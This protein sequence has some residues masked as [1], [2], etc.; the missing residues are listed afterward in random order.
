VYAA[1]GYEIV[2]L[3]EG[4][5][6]PLR[7]LKF[8]V[9]DYG[10]LATG[11]ACATLFLMSISVL[12]SLPKL[13]EDA[14]PD[15]EI[16]KSTYEFW[17]TR[18]ASLPLGLMQF[19]TYFAGGFAIYSLLGFP[20]GNHSKSL[21]VVFTSLQYAFGGVI[22]RKLWCLGH[23]LR[24]LE[25]VDPREDLLESESLPRLIYAVNIFTFLTLLMTTVHT[26]FHANIQYG[27]H[28]EL[29]SILQPI[30]YLPL[31]L[32]MPVIVLFNFYPR[33]VVNRLYLKSIRQRKD[34]LTRKIERSD[35]SDIS[36]FKHTID[37]EKYLNEEF[38]YRQRVALSE[39]PVAL[40]VILALI[41]VAVRLW[42][43]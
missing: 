29:L 2:R 20:V 43:T 42:A 18:F 32:A 24:S 30:V 16:K 39:L 8:F 27:P 38:R 33:M 23:M 9:A 21:L 37:Y 3:L 22:G 5:D 13:I 12:G 31:I 19:T 28:S 35:E 11:T 1:A 14:I 25:V 4:D 15:S 40:T 17:R 36:K 34:R 6:E 7:F 26:Y 10:G 41:A